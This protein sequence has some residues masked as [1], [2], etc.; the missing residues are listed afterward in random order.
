MAQQSSPRLTV[1]NFGPIKSGTIELKPLTILIGPNNSGKSY[2]A[3]LAYA[4]LRTISAHTRNTEPSPFLPRLYQEPP[5]FSPEAREWFQ[6]LQETEAHIPFEK[7]PATVQD[8]LV[9]DVRQ[10]EAMLNVEIEQAILDYFSVKHLVHLQRVEGGLDRPMSIRLHGADQATPLIDIVA[11]TQPDHIVVRLITPNVANRSFFPREAWSSAPTREDDRH[12]AMYFRE[13]LLQ[14]LWIQLR[15]ENGLPSVDPYILPA[16][17]SGMLQGYQVFVAL[18]LSIVRR[19]AGRGPVT[20]PA[21]QGVTG[22]FFEELSRKVPSEKVR[23]RNRSVKSALQYLEHHV[24]KGQIGLEEVESGQ[25][26]ITYRAGVVNLPIDRASSMVAELAP[27]ALWISDLIPGDCLFIDEPEAH[28]HP[29]NQRRIATVL[30]RLVR[31]GVRVVVATHSSTI[32]HQISNH[33]IASRLPAAKRAEFGFTDDDVLDANEVGVFLFDVQE[34]GTQIRPVT[35]D[36]EF[37]IDEEEFVRVSQ[38]L[39]NETYDL[40]TAMQEQAE[41]AAVAP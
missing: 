11:A 32:L 19:S 21:F 28:L 10:V 33:L 36:P 34:D 22:D 5:N 8:M 7:F 25:P 39:G 41:S 12:K 30:A 20:I 16:A 38:A 3:T 27:L 35:I 23:R 37:G 15:S 6:G 24:F 2:M 40:L 4:L 13:L 17:R 29:E 26:Q 14:E 9:D 1:E 18:A 31:A